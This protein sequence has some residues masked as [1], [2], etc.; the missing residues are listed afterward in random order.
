MSM[1]T[2]ARPPAKGSGTAA[3]MRRG[4]SSAAAALAA[5]TVAGCTSV[6]QVGILTRPVADPG[7]I[8]GQARAFEE[9]GPAEGKSCRFFVL[10]V[11]PFGDS[12]ASEAMEEALAVTGGNAMIN[13]TIESSLYGFIP[14]YNLLSFTCTT[15]RGIAIR[16]DAAAEQ[17]AGSGPAGVADRTDVAQAAD[18]RSS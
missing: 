6:G 15:V 1:Y 14:I 8:I 5:L 13:V 12:T 10:G 2:D 7:A 3:A 18:D 4:R 11:V 16:L 17:A 9:I